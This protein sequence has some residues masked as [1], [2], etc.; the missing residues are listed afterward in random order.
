[1]KENKMLKDYPDVLK[2]W[3]Y[4]LNIDVLIPEFLPAHSNKQYY[5][6]CDE[7][8]PSY[9]CSL[10]KKT[11]RNYGCPVCSNHKV[12]KGINDFKSSNPQLMLDW[13]YELNK[14]IDPESLSPKSITVVNWK[15][16]ICGKK[17]Q[18]RIR[19]ATR[20]TINCPA[21]SLVDRGHKKHLSSLKQNGG[22]T[23]EDLLIDWDYVKNE[24]K[25]SEYSPQG[26]EYAFWKCHICGYEWKAKISNR[27]HG[28]GCPCCGNRVLIKDR[29]DFET[30][31]PELAKEWHPTKNG[32]LRPSDV[33]PGSA[34]K[35]W[36]LCPAGHEYE[37]SLNKRTSGQGTNCPICNSGRQTSFREQAL[38]YY[39]K[40]L[41]PNTIS[42]YKPDNFGKFELDIFIPEL[43]RAIEYDGVAWHKE[44]K[45]ERER[46]KYELCKKLGIKLIRVKEKMPE[47]LGLQLAD[48]IISSDDFESEDGF[49]KVI[50]TVL[51][52]I[53]MGQRLYWINPIDV[54]LSRD[55]FEIMKY[56]TQ[57]KHSFADEYPELANEWHPTKNGTLKPTM[58]KPK[59]GFKAWWLCPKCGNEY[60]QQLGHRAEGTGCPKCALKYMGNQYRMN[61][62][63]KKGSITNP[64]LLKEW[65]YEKNGDLVPEQFTNSSDYKVWWK[66]SKCGYEWESRIKDRKKAKNC[67]KCAGLELFIGENDFAT[68]HPDLLCEWD[69]KKNVGLDPCKIHHGSNMMVWWKCS[70]CGNE[71]QAPV[72]RRDKGSGCRKCSDKSN[73]ALAMKTLV[74]K[75]GSLGDVCPELVKEYSPENKMSI[76][77][78]SP[79]SGKKVKWICS[80]CGFEWEA[81]PHVRKRGSGCPVCGQKKSALNRRKR[82]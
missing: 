34:R 78:I 79:G 35:V 12:I 81:P 21:C 57:I 37:S 13:D 44:N 43:N 68:L 46:R 60:E 41:Y 36:W 18:G 31:Y 48:Y 24:R 59:S 49:T 63:K 4:E 70:K 82:K 61:L 20:K 74:A 52:K 29:N 38:F 72:C 69:Y 6:K 30:R 67:P 80:T 33:M 77:E 22:I 19:D 45:Y 56:A 50:H 11:M 7:G 8:H 40:K 42:R 39:I 25:P 28:R 58:F 17:W 53:S 32:S 5:W 1:M 9:L 15:C 27:A 14:D 51:G 10:D 64:I 54:N 3:D 2:Q 55:R 62:I 23:R 65:N 26:N 47:D 16:H 73:V 71:Y 76:Y 66:C 75:R